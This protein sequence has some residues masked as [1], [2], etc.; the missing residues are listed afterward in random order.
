MKNCLECNEPSRNA[1]FCSNK[2]K[3][4]NYY[5][6]NK[7]RLNIRSYARQKVRRSERK[8]SLVERTGGQCKICSYSSCLA[9]LTFH[10]RE[11]SQKAFT[12]SH[13]SKSFKT[14][15]KE[16][17]K[18]DLLCIRCHLEL[19]DRLYQPQAT[20]S[21]HPNRYELNRQRALQRKQK[22][23]NLKGG[24]CLKC[25]YC[26][27]LRSLSFHHRDPTKKS[28]TLDLRTTGNRSWKILLAEVT[29][30]DLYCVRCHAEIEAAIRQGGIEPPTCN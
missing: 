11:R 26:R 9:A 1:K 4:K 3:G 23:V 7:Q 25:G 17:E 18:C 14:I 30:C 16:A 24:K 15:K 6:N 29:K 2:C 10:H 12:I 5:H 27:C 8:Q 19:E 20:N 28:F 21:T 13:S 22:L